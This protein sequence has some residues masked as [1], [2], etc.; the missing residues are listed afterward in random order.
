MMSKNVRLIQEEIKKKNSYQ[1]Y[2]TDYTIY[3][4][5][6]DHDSFPYDKFFRGDAQ[7]SKPKVYERTAGWAP[8]KP[9]EV[10]PI[11]PS[12]KPQHCFQGPCSVIYPCYASESNNYYFL[13]KACVN[14]K[15]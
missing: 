13:N 14:E 4:V 15:R 2:Y 3:S 8:K 12:E 6:N 9:R 5:M 7:S 11:I 1:P 10:Q